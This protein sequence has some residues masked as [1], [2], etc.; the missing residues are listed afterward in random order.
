VSL[1]SAAVYQR[2]GDMLAMTYV[3]TSKN[4]RGV[5]LASELASLLSKRLDAVPDP[6]GS[7]PTV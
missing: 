6:T 4:G 5:A 7:N 3:M 1:R 2:R